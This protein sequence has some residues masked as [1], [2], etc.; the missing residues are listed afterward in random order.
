LDNSLLGPAVQFPFSPVS[1][2]L[3][4]WLVGW[5]LFRGLVD[6]R[7][8]T[9]FP[10]GYL[11]AS[12]WQMSCSEAGAWLLETQKQPV[13]LPAGTSSLSSLLMVVSRAVSSMGCDQPFG[14]G[15]VARLGIRLRHGQV[16]LCIG[17]CGARRAAVVVCTVSCHRLR[18]C[19]QVPLSCEFCC[20]AC[21]CCCVVRQR[22]L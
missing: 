17:R 11:F 22:L 8:V 18:I 6:D 15:Y 12:H 10:S 7:Q 5:R 16:L 3:A 13:G 14:Q 19:W 1:S 2:S 21:F 9:E 20:A 4:G